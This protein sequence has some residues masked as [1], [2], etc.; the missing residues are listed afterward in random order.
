MSRM[1]SKPVLGATVA[2]AAFAV[3]VS[4]GTLAVFSDTQTVG[5]NAFT[6]STISLGVGTSSALVSFSNMLPGDVVTNPIVLT[7]ATGSSALRYAISASATNTDSKAL[8]D[9]LVLT[10]K[11]IDVTLPATPCDNFDG[12]QVYTGD[13]DNAAA[14][15]GTLGRIAGDPAQGAQTG[16]R[17]LA[18]AGTETLCFRVSL[19]LATGNAFKLATTT[20]TIQFDA[21]QSANN[22]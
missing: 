4:V 9:Q 1:L 3:V 8:K 16:D 13:L 17:A 11:T 15:A 5:A 10:V 22:P 20:G 6:D 2:T 12:T 18:V 14:T 21:E 19:P 7:N